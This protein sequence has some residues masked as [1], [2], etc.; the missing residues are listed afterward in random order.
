MATTS[1]S[2]GP[3]GLMTPP[4]SA[5]TSFDSQDGSSMADVQMA[6]RNMLLGDEYFKSKMHRV[7]A[8][9]WNDDAMEDVAGVP[10]REH[11]KVSQALFSSSTS[12]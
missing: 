5:G 8:D 3:T 2:R 12:L 1:A 9:E 7:V 4:S 10:T 11:W 6:A